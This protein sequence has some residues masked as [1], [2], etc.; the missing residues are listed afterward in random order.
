[1]KYEAYFTGGPKHQQIVMVRDDTPEIHFA[2]DC[3][4]TVGFLGPE[5]ETPLETFDVIVYRLLAKTD[6][7]KLI[8]EF[9]DNEQD[10]SRDSSVYKRLRRN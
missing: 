9:V 6:N 5:D 10:Q 3:V 7:G 2:P 8:Y 1:M 4:N